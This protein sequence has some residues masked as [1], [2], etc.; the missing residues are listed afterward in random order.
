M[1]K[2]TSTIIAAM[3]F[4]IPSLCGAMDF[5]A[6]QPD[7]AKKIE[8][9]KEEVRARG[10]TYEVAYSAAMDK[11]IEHLTGLKVP[12]GWNKSDAPSVAMLR[13]SVQALPS[14]LD[15]RSLNGVTPIKNQGNCGDCWAFGTVGPLESQ[16]LL[17]N[18]STVDLSEQYLVSCN[19]SGWSCDGGWWAH[20]YHMDLAGQ[21][22]NSPGAVLA[23]SDPYTGTDSA[24]RGPY[25]HPYKLT[26]WAYV[27]SEEAV[28][29]IDEIKQAIYTYGPISA[30]VYAGPEFQVYS[31]GIFNTN[32]SGQ[33]NH[34][35]VLV[36]WND[37]L[38]PDNGYWIL[39]NSWGTSWGESG[40]MRIRYGINQVGYAA[41]FIEYGGGSPNPTPSPTSVNVP[42]VVGVTQAAA[43]AELTGEGLVVGTVTTQSSTAVSSGSV[44]SQNP[45][46]DASVASGSAV[47]LVVSSGPA[48]PP[49]SFSCFS[50]CARR[51][52]R[53]AG[54][55]NRRTYRRRARGWNRDNPIEHG[56]RL[57]V[58]HKPEPGG[59]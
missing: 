14:S 27:G 49:P 29:T 23:A 10:G 13:S 57:R 17:Q 32:E 26:N 55:G 11:K 35:I 59:G 40:Y 21:D 50:E 6:L 54:C 5:Q 22:N 44:I 51:G 28:P 4:T 12:P 46:A 42:D 53:Y 36:G 24:C 33:I 52:G 34:A 37:D 9:L 19:L 58:G 31:G 48:P 8:A 18:N 15:W 41:N 25:N 7:M 47:N 20:D 30:A 43:T 3:F 16:I 38:G 39:R 56:R 2:L 45:A 1:K